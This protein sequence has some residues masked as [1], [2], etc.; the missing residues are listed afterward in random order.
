MA[1]GGARRLPH[2]SALGEESMKLVGP[3]RRLLRRRHEVRRRDVDEVG[4]EAAPQVVD[5]PGLRL[6]LCLG[7]ASLSCCIGVPQEGLAPVAMQ[8]A[9]PHCFDIPF[10]A[11][12]Q[13]VPKRLPVHEGGG[14]GAVFAP[15]GSANELQAVAD[16]SGRRHAEDL[17][18]ES[19]RHEDAVDPR[20]AAPGVVVERRREAVPCA[21][22]DERVLFAEG[23][24]RGAVRVRRQPAELAEHH[25]GDK[26]RQP[27]PCVRRGVKAEVNVEV[28]KDD[29]HRAVGQLGDEAAELVPEELDLR[30]C[31]GADHQGRL[32]AEDG[33]VERGGL[34]PQSADAP[35]ERRS[36]ADDAP[37]LRLGE[38]LRGEQQGDA[39]SLVRALAATK[40]RGPMPLEEPAGAPLVDPIAAAVLRPL[41]RD[42]MLAGE[43]VRQIIGAANGE[44]GLEV[45]GD[46]APWGS[47]RGS[48]RRPP[49]AGARRADGPCLLADLARRWAL[50]HRAAAP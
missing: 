24:E 36:W 46:D 22:V 9:A 33:E 44:E 35:R 49:A 31:A 5:E 38:P 4:A 48:R 10:A 47:T 7:D 25:A 41:Q 27:A 32:D 6:R 18:V 30:L 12:L 20:D 17:R 39:A 11:R 23:L 14:D 2:F 50:F 8:G 15:R 29:G 28:A 37:H 34:D 43:L 26:D 1:A 45:V 19:A 16:A 13:R 21:K 40:R 3:E 42:D